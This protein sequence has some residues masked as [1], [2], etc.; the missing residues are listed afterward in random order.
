MTAEVVQV[1]PAP[2]NASTSV[3]LFCFRQLSKADV[4]C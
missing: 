3:S 1:P 4:K 2:E